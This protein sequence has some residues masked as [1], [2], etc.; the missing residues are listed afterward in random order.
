MYNF[1]QEQYINKSLS[2]LFPF[3]ERP[4]NLSKL[5]P[6]W[7]SFKIKTPLPIQMKE[8]ATI[9]YSIKLFGIPM[10]WKTEIIKYSPPFLFIDEQKKGP[11]KKWV[12]THSF[13]EINGKV[14]MKDKIDY[15]LYGG[16]LKHL[17]HK[18]FV[19]PL[20]NKIFE[21]RKITIEKEFGFTD[22][23]KRNNFNNLCF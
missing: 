5:T 6:S 17:I 14:L 21:F 8:G 10:N 15:D 2:K 12:H 18:F 13:E 20:I 1:K 11:Y 16:I 3:F 22:N 4:E 23:N 7:L 9:E 19:K